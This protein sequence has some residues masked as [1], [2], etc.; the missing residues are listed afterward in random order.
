MLL[1]YSTGL[2]NKMQVVS[3]Y[4]THKTKKIDKVWKQTSSW[5]S[6]ETPY[7]IRI[8]DAQQIYTNNVLGRF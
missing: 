2:Y 4:D 7:F 6:V 1:F 8:T 3:P 5:G